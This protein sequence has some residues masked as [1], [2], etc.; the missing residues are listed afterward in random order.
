MSHLC[1]GFAL[2]TWVSPLIYCFP[3]CVI[4]S[5]LVDLIICASCICVDSI[6]TINEGSLRASV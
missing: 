3:C 1:S 6:L 2:D 4:V 5:L